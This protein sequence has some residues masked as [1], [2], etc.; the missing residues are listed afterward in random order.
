M[1]LRHAT[2]KAVAFLLAAPAPGIGAPGEKILVR[3]PADPTGYSDQARSHLAGGDY[4]RAIAVCRAGLKADSTSTELLN[5]LATAL[6]EEGRYALAIEAL[7][8]VAR[9]APGSVLT[10]LN[11]GGI[12]TKLG[13]YD[14]AEKNLSR[15]SAL[16]P[17]QPEIRRRLAEVYLGTD[18]YDQ[19]AEQIEHALRLFP[20]DATLFYFLGRSLEGDGRERAALD[21]FESA[22]RLDIS[23]SEAFYRTALLAR[24]LEQEEVSQKAMK[25]YRHLGQVGAGSPRW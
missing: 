5:L 9:L 14:A 19:A 13:Q 21:A 6:A 23:F 4:S 1:I 10:Y 18:R 16:A 15:A 17:S 11:L 25:R 7:E 3:T 8:K 24:K 20:D 12:H 2:V 22:S